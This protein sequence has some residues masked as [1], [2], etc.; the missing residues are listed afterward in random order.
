MSEENTA[1]SSNTRV[2]FFRPKKTVNASLRKREIDNE[3]ENKKDNNGNNEVLISLI[4]SIS[5]NFYD[6]NNESS[7][8]ENDSSSDLSDSA[9]KPHKVRINLA[10]KRKKLRGRNLI[11]TVKV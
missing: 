6:K 11:Q 5:I 2:P 4:Y 3:I 9:K 10:E 1:N 8:N 7:G